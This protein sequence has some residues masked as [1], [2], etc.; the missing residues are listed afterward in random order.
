MHSVL[1]L[2][3]AKHHFSNFSVLKISK[4]AILAFE[5]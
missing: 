1:G 4:N 2:S 3:L 5:F